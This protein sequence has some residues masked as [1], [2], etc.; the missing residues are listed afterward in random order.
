MPFG[1]KIAGFSY[2]YLI[3]KPHLSWPVI[4]HS[5][6]ATRGSWPW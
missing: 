5:S 6:P 1:I 3:G 2:W 4:T